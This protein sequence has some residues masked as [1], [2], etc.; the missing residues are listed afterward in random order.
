MPIAARSRT[1][2]LARDFRERKRRRALSLLAARGD[3]M[4]CR[5]AELASVVRVGKT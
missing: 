4:G 5:S 1:I 2:A 3:A